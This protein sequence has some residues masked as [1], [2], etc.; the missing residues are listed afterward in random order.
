MQKLSIILFVAIVLIGCQS[1][2]SRPSGT[3]VE[4]L[5]YSIAETNDVSYAGTPRLVYRITLNVND[6]PDQ[7]RMRKTAVDIWQD[8]NKKWSEFTVFM[9]LPEMNTN[10]LAYVVAEFSPSGMKEFRVLKEAL[11]FTKW[12]EKKSK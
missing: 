10:D 8:G 7:P 9:Y 12:Q 11:Y 2:E 1:N 5:E 6:I 4:P 3:Q